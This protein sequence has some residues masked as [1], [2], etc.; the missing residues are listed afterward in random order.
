MLI[1]AW[2]DS[3]ASIT[4]LEL[5][6]RHN[7]IKGVEKRVEQPPEDHGFGTRQFAQSIF[8]HDSYRDSRN[9]MRQSEKIARLGQ[10]PESCS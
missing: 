1:Q 3:Q 10:R 8:V 5:R 9:N 2:E 6:T 4:T 7:E